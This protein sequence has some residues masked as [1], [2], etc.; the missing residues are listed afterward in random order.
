MLQVVVLRLTY[1]IQSFV[2][3]SLIGDAAFDDAG[4]CTQLVD[5][6][7][8]ITLYALVVREL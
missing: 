8:R 5:L 2:L 3:V 7:N 1:S 4:I 6:P